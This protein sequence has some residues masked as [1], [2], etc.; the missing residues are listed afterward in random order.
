MGKN[1]GSSPGEKGNTAHSPGNTNNRLKKTRFCL[2][3]NNYSEEDYQDI[4]TWVNGSC[5]MW[6]I[7]REI[8]DS[9]TPHLQMFFITNKRMRITEFKNVKCLYKCHVEAAKGSDEENIKYC[10][11]DKNFKHSINCNVPEELKIINILSPWQE[12]LEDIIIN[13]TSERDIYWIWEDIGGVGKTAFIKYMIAKHNCLLCGGGKRADVI[14]IIFNNKNYMTR[15]GLKVVLF[16][17]PRCNKNISW[18]AIEEIKNGVIINTKFET[19]TFIC[20][21]PVVV[22]VSN[23][24]PDITKLSLDRWNIYKIVNNSLV[25]EDVNKMLRNDE[26]SE[27]DF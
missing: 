12:E 16:D 4:L 5:S 9:G 17:I 24:R 26:C 1:S 20:N 15:S 23:E 13:C 2:T 21:S 18:G 19:G 6:I 27:N 3:Y 7:G 22:I 14:N 10:S 25:F 11:K 8:G